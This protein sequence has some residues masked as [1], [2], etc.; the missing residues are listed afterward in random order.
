MVLSERGS[1]LRKMAPRFS[2][3]FGVREF[4]H[5]FKKHI[6][7]FGHEVLPFRYDSSRTPNE[8]VVMVDKAVWTT[9]D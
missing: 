5:L 8:V 2:L 3:S 7:V 6:A 1:P 4:P 9:S